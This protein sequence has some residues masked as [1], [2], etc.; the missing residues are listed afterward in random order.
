[1]KGF[2]VLYWNKSV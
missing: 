1:V 2:K